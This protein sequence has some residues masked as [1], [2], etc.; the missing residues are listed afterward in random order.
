[1]LSAHEAC[2]PSSVEVSIVVLL[3]VMASSRGYAGRSGLTPTLTPTL[4]VT[5]TLTPSPSR[6]Q[7]GTPK[8]AESS[9]ARSG[10]ECGA[11][12]AT[13]KKFKI[14]EGFRA[15]YVTLKPN[16]L[17]KRNKLID[18][19]HGC[20]DRQTDGGKVYCNPPPSAFRSAVLNKHPSTTFLFSFLFSFGILILSRTTCTNDRL[21]AGDVVE[22][23]LKGRGRL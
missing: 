1:M 13:T 14:V 21:L 4:I 16:Q 12:T 22:Y 11:T 20:F 10:N 7:I 23:C 6:H 19:N 15:G 3:F 9:Q 18:S 17:K 8:P 2:L 5:V